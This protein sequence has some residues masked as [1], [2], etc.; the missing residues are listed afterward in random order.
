MDVSPMQLETTTKVPVEKLRLDPGNQRLIGTE[1]DIADEAIVA[2]LYRAAELNE[3][4]E[5]I[6]TNGYL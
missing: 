5:S 3:L 2:R 1:N 4:L 6:S